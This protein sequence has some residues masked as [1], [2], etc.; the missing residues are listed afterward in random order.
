MKA[1][2]PEA[3]ADVDLLLAY[4]VPD[5]AGGERPFVRCNMISSFDGAVTVNG[6]SGALGGTADRRI[7]AILRSFADVVLVG[8]GTAR[9]E[10]YG[11]VRLDDRLRGLRMARGQTAVPPIAVVTRSVNLDWSS[12]FFTA[13]EQRPIVFVTRDCENDRQRRGM[14]VA[15]VVVAGDARVDVRFVMGYFHDSGYRSVLLEGGPGLNGDVARAGLLDEL[16]LTMSPRLVAG[17]GP[18]LLAGDELAQ[19][20]DLVVL[21]LLEQEGS[22]FYRLGIR[23]SANKA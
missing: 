21:H 19:P 11:P 7:F 23:S 18:R 12:P 4:G 8:A 15:E 3:A 22:L 9:A 16:C 1:L 10:N 6:R 13:A 5:E 20:L 14:E 17:H 2:L